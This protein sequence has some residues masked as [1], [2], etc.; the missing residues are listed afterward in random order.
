[1]FVLLSLFWRCRYFA[2]EATDE[3]YNGFVLGGYT[4]GERAARAVLKAKQGE[5]G[6]V[7][8]DGDGHPP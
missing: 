3:D 6:D 1:M 4:S 5:D 7:L 8:G 2:G